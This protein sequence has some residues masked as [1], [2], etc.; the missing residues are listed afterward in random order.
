M[1]KKLVAALSGGAVLVLALSGCS[2][3]GGEVDAYAKKVCDDVQPQLK[4][5]TQANQAIK[6]SAADDKPQ[7]VKKTDSA[8]F[9]QISDAYA[10]LSDSVEKAGTPPVDNGAQ[11]QKDAVKELDAT[12]KAYAELKQQTDKLNTKTRGTFADGLKK[13]IVDIERVNEVGNAAIRKLQS[14]EIGTAMAKQTSCQR[15]T[16]AP[17]AA[18]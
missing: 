9:Q 11:I 7:N 4:K 8:A 15:T 1:N 16:K 14:G 13:L 3:D 12:S 5:I 17:S 18:S 2:D 10:A 6:D